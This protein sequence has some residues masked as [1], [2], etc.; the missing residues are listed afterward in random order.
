MIE[1]LLTLSFILVAYLAKVGA[2]IL[3]TMMTLFAKL[4][5]QSEG[6]TSTDC[7]QA[8]ELPNPNQITSST[9][10]IKD[11][12]KIV[13]LNNNLESYLASKRKHHEQYIHLTNHT[14]PDEGERIVRWILQTPHMKASLKNIP[15]PSEHAALRERIEP[16]LRQHVTAANGYVALK[17]HWW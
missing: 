9:F 2:L 4:R 3:S 6:V 14:T 16:I 7:Q 11:S 8:D 1:F 17:D 5:T 10:Q 15:I 12:G 13:Y